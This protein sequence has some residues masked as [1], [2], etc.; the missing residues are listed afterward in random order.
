[1]SDDFIEKVEKSYERHTGQEWS[2]EKTRENFALY[3][4]AKR[5]QAMEQLDDA[6]KETPATEGALRTY[7]RL[8][9]LQRDL[10]RMHQMMIR[11][12]R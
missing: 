8:T 5:I 7:T 9:G 4:K 12:G 3:G 10:E 2:P 11:N 1:M 6:I